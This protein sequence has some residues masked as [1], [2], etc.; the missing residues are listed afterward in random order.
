MKD[1]KNANFNSFIF[2]PSDMMNMYS[3]SFRKII[4]II[5]LVTFFFQGCSGPA[6]DS[7]LVEADSGKGFHFP[8]L[9][10]IPSGAS[11]HAQGYLIVEPNNT[12]QVTDDFDV[13]LEYARKMLTRDF[14]LGNYLAGELQFPLLIPVFPR[15]ESQ[16]QVYTHALDRD[17][18]LKKN[19]DLKRPDLQLLAMIA[20][21]RGRLEDMGLHI[22]QQIIMTGFSASG[23]FANRFSMIHPERIK[24]LV[25]GGLNGFLMMPFGQYQGEQLEYPLGTAD[26]VLLT[27]RPFNREAFAAIPQLLFMGQEDN[28][29]ALPY[30]D[31][32]SDDHRQQVYRLLGRQM[33]PDRW[34]NCRQIYL[35]EGFNTVIKTYSGI[36]HEHPQEVKEEMVRFVKEAID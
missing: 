22:D 29:D 5:F 35:S 10:L 36:G 25:A 27:G 19:S 28:N 4:F 20:D 34:D 7:I 13:H 30:T 32:Y 23:T 16:P 21:A 6:P 14:Y 15:Q 31:S 12:G 2:Q 1:S 8:Y 9:L 17:V 26:M 11:D 24:A 3:T 33:M 18:M